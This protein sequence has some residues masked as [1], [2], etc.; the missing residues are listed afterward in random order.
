[1][2]LTTYP[3]I[4]LRKKCHKGH[5]TYGAYDL[6]FLHTWDLFF[7]VL[8]IIVTDICFVFFT[9]LCC[10]GRRLTIKRRPSKHN[11]QIRDFRIPPCL[12]SS[13]M[14]LKIGW[15]LPAF[16][17]SLSIP[18]SRGK[19]QKSRNVA[20]YQSTLCNVPKEGRSPN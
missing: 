19:Q 20:N 10:L 18:S 4:S 1:M 13:G 11:N 14:L 12:H 6:G 5:V 15:Y 8:H 3:L 7:R 17:D 9:L 16:R 2:L